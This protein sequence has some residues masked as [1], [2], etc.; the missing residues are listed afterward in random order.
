MLPTLLYCYHCLLRND[1]LPYMSSKRLHQS[2]AKKTTH[3]P[4]A[5]VTAKEDAKLAG[6]EDIIIA[7]VHVRHAFVTYLPYPVYAFFVDMRYTEYAN[8]AIN[9]LLLR[10]DFS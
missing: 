4:R 2:E 9:H 7:S 10:R 6:Q 8:F 5:N 1:L 3:I